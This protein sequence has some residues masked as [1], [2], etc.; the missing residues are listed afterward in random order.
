MSNNKWN[1]SNHT[2]QSIIIILLLVAMIVFSVVDFHLFENIKDQNM[3]T[4]SILRL[5]GGFVFIIIITGFGYSKLFKA[6]HFWK[7]LVIIIPALIISINNFPIIAFLDGRAV[8][9]E[10]VYRVYLFFIECLTTGFF[11][12]II[13]RGIIL[14]FLVNKFAHLKN[15]LLLSIVMSSL[16]FGLIHIFNLYSGASIIDTLMQVGYSFLVGMMWA[17]MF[18]KTKNIWLVM[19]LHATFN[20]FGQVMFYLGNVD[21]RYDIYTIVLT[22]VLAIM[23]SLYVIKQ[24]NQINSSDTMPRDIA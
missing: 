11:E 16:F 6:S 3:I 22:I 20:F 21:G 23:V 8:L 1:M 24:Y 15:G 4:N 10:P 5:L 9:T 17:V 7:S 14:I 12:E 13:F 18:L 19:I 2:F